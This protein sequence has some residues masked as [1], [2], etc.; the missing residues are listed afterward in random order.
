M[1]IRCRTVTRT[2]WIAF[3]TIGVLAGC[4]E[5]APPSAEAPLQSPSIPAVPTPTP[6]PALEAKADESVSIMPVPPQEHLPTPDDS[7]CRGGGSEGTI[8][9]DAAIHQWTDAQ[10]I[11]HFSDQAPVGEVSNHRVIAVPGTPPVAIEASGYDVNLPTDLNQRAVA[12][13][14]A[15][16]RILRE[17][18][19]VT[20]EQ[21][22]RLKI[23]FV[24]SPQTY[25]SL[26]DEPRL[27]SSDG[28]YS[29]RKQ[30]VYVR[31]QA[32]AELTFRVLRHEI[33]HALL[34]ER[35]GNLALPINEGIAAYFERLQT[36]AQGGQVDIG[37]SRE[38]LARMAPA[39]A[40][41][42]LVDLLSSNPDTF[43]GASRD[44][45]YVRAFALIAQL[46]QDAPGRAALARLLKQQYAEPCTPIAAERVFAAAYPGGLKQLAS[47]WQH[48]MQA[49]P[50]NVHAF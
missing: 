8:V 23:V 25:A 39:D 36:V 49:S 31:M 9:R 32:S 48:W 35:V 50:A 37:G 28:A 4:S 40:S 41:L 2:Q 3:L 10:G 42:A 17:T 27:A 44:S 24:Q 34:H 15:I 38:L 43:Y 45:N 26:I 16:D 11:R 5:P 47:D 7:P 29:A 6:T 21:R 12:D 33:T 19:G 1:L 14:L 13:A 22:L 30:T 18:L 20:G 46:M